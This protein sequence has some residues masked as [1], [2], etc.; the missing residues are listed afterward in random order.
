MCIC[1]QTPPNWPANTPM[2]HTHIVFAEQQAIH[3]QAQLAL[4]R[5]LAPFQFTPPPTHTQT[6]THAQHTTPM[7]IKN[8]IITP[9]SSSININSNNVSSNFSNFN[10]ISYMKNLEA[11]VGAGVNIEAAKA[12]LASGYVYIYI[13]M[14]VCVCVYV[15][16]C[17]YVCVCVCIYNS[18]GYKEH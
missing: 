5:S 3:Q 15:Y 6:H 11:L 16:V 14:C 7:G 1:I 10:N 8:S 2:S 13:Y 9:N 12:F 4:S 17:V 18:N